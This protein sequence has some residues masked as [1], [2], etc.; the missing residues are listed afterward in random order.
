MYRSPKDA[1][2]N[3]Y[4]NIALVSALLLTVVFG[5]L[6]VD[7]P[8]CDDCDPDGILQ[9]I[10]VTSTWTSILSFARVTVECVVNLVLY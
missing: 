3:V 2:R 5:M 10:Y 1:V 9:A 7:Q 6:Q 8:E 4:T